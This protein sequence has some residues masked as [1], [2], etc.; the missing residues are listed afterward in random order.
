[1]GV[2]MVCEKYQIYNYNEWQSKEKADIGHMY[3]VKF[4][5]I[6]TFKRMAP[7]CDSYVLKSPKD[8]IEPLQAVRKHKKLLICQYRIL[9]GL[10]L[11]EQLSKIDKLTWFYGTFA[12]DVRTVEQRNNNGSGC[13]LI[14][15][16][17]NKNCEN[18]KGC[19]EHIDIY[20]AKMKLPEKW[21][22][23]CHCGY[24]LNDMDHEIIGLQSSFQGLIK[25]FL[26]HGQPAQDQLNSNFMEWVF[27]TYG[28]DAS[29]DL[30]QCY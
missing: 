7:K 12:D 14:H 24:G 11:D 27:Q 4:G 2:V 21:E 20:D 9:H 6:P 25:S 19:Y 8:L 3:F 29:A 17:D 23:E 16:C 22:L 15:Y 13:V 5:K 28:N 1:M 10:W 26:Y 30:R 18:P